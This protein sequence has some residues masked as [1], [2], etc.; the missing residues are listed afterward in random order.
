MGTELY[1]LIRNAQSISQALVMECV[2]GQWQQMELL[3]KENWGR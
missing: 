2:L 1:G 3:A